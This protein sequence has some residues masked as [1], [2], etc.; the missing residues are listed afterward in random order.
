MKKIFI[1]TILLFAK[2]ALSQADNSFKT[3]MNTPVSAFD[4]FLYRLYENAQCN[5]WSGYKLIGTLKCM[6]RLPQYNPENNELILS[7]A[8]IPDN[9]DKKTIAYLKRIK[10]VPKEQKLKMLRAGMNALMD[11]LGLIKTLKNNKKRGKMIYGHGLLDNSWIQ[12]SFSKKTLSKIKDNTIV[13]VRFSI[14][15]TTEYWDYKGK[16]DKNGN[17]SVEIINRGYILSQVEL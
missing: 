13:N 3:L 9:T 1:L 8:I 2:P 11:D 5:A 16:R 7:L 10:S 15:K 14:S 17:I 6:N 12:K 4:L